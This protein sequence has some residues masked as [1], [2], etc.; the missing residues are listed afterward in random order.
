MDHLIDKLNMMYGVNM[1]IE[2][3]IDKLRKD[4]E[5]DEGIKHEIYLCSL[6]KPTF[7]IGH[8]VLSSDPESQMEIGDKV[9]KERV[10]SVFED[11]IKITIEDC[12]KIFK[13]W[14]TLPEVARLVTANMCFQ[15]GRPRLSK[16]K[17]TVSACNDHRWTDMANEMMDSRWYSQTKNRADRLI[18]RIL[19]LDESADDYKDSN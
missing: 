16:F 12:K 3:F 2:L 13:D 17:K 14:Q 15:L 1:V 6:G 5:Q 9:S 4:L 7:G 18:K 11:D 10:E 19:S 8:L